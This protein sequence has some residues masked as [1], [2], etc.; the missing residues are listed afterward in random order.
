MGKGAMSASGDK[1]GVSDGHV[2]VAHAAE[3]TGLSKEAIRARIRRHSLA[4]ERRNGRHRI[5]VAE[6][7]RQGLVVGGERYDALRRRADSLEAQLR[8]ALERRQRAQREL[9]EARET[10]RLVW[11][12]VRQKDRELAELQGAPKRPGRIRWP[13]RRS[14][15]RVAENA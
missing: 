11:G 12:M 8:A 10:V 2:D 1:A 5:P 9:E 6:L 15:T 13:W 4:S 7:R 3:L 14:A